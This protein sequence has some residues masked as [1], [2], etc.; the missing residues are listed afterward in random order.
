[1]DGE[2]PVRKLLPVSDNF[3]EVEKDGCH[4]QLQTIAVKVTNLLCWYERQ[5]VAKRLMKD[6]TFFGRA[7]YEDDRMELEWIVQKT[8][9]L[10]VMHRKTAISN[11]LNK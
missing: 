11:Y 8:N 6:K 10:E 1:M 3:T 5:K 2:Q 9:N 7:V 4:T